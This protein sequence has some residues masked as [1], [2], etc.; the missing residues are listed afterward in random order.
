MVSG[1]GSFMNRWYSFTKSNPVVFGLFPFFVYLLKS[2]LSEC[3]APDKE[4][5][6]N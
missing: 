5:Q 6:Q 2:G 3:R 4:H 1:N